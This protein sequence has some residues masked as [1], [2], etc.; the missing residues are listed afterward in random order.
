MLMMLL[1]MARARA[2]V[3]GC[4][5]YKSIIS[6]MGQAARPARAARPSIFLLEDPKRFISK[7][8][9]RTQYGISQYLAGLQTLV[10]FC[11]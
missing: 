2:H 11:I 1:Y 5:T 10:M 6:A 9:R 4:A 7:S 3:R 8:K